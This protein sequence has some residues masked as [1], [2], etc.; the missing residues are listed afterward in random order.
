MNVKW[1]CKL[2]IVGL[3]NGLDSKR[4]VGY[5]EVHR[6]KEKRATEFGLKEK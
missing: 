4:K 5:T 2:L 6:E 1:L 3:W